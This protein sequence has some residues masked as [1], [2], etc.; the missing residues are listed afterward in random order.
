LAE[1]NRLAC[2]DLLEA[3]EQDRQPEANMYE[4][5]QTI[6]MISAVFASQLAGGPVDLPLAVRSAPLARWQ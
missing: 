6:E 3:I 2:L 4:A 5:R 1:G